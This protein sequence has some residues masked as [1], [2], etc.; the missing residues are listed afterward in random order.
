MKLFSI[1]RKK[2]QK[3]IRKRKKRAFSGANRTRFTQWMN[4]TFTPIN[5]DLKAGLM[6]LII[7]SRSL[8]QNNEIF[9]SH[10]NN[11]LKNIIGSVGFRLQSVITTDGEL[12][13]LLNSHLEKVWRDFGKA[14]N[15]FITKCGQMS[16]LDFDKL[17]LQSLIIDGEVFIHIDRSAKNPY[18][19]SFSLLDPMNLDYTRNREKNAGQNAIIMGIEVDEYYKPVNYYF[20]EGTSDNY[21]LG[22]QV[23]Y[24]PEE[25]IHIYQ[26]QFIGQVRGFPM[27]CASL[28]SLKQLD[29]FAIAQLFAAKVSA[30]QGIFYQRNN[31]SNSGDILD[32]IDVEEDNGDFLEELAPGMTSIVPEGYSVKSLT[33]SHPNSNFSGFVKAIVRRVASAFGI[34]YNTLSHDYESVSYSSLREAA[35]SENATYEMIQKFIIQNWKEKEYELFLKSYLINSSD[36]LLRPSKYQEYLKY[37]FIGKKLPYFDAA[38]DIIATERR[39]KLGITNPI[40]EIES[41]G[42]DAQQVLNG[43]VIWKKMCEDRK[44]DFDNGEVLPLDIVTQVN[45]EMN[46]D[47]PIDEN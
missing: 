38:K 8:A 28:Q 1:L 25:I 37:N 30:C 14:S 17:I 20:R 34:S 35:I 29:D 26:K 31:T 22:K 23:I 16:D 21:Q 33:P 3:P 47:K 45:N 13:N 4:A 10:I 44:I 18:G 41:H 2:E 5:Q 40:M 7:K 11:M 32:S 43:W 42:Y 24:K 39:L 15:G 36:L 27:I 9:R 46:E 12:D 19:I 6:P